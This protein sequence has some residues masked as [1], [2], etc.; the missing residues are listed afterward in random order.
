MPEQQKALIAAFASVFAASF[1][2]VFIRI[3]I[4]SGVNPVLLAFWRL[5]LTCLFMLPYTLSKSRYRRELRSLSKK[6]LILIT[7]AGLLLALHFSSWFISLKYTSTVSSTLLVCSEPAF[8]LI[9]A[10]IIYREKTNI[11]SIPGLL[12]AAV[13]VFL[14]ALPEAGNSAVTDTSLTGNFLALFGAICISGYILVGRGIMASVSTMLY[15]TFV[16]SVCCLCLGIMVAAMGVSFTAI[17]RTGFLMAICLAFFCQFLGNTTSNWSLKYI[18]AA[19]VSS[20]YLL[21]PV[22]TA[23]LVFLIWREVPGIAVI[24]GGL[25]LLSGILY[26]IRIEAAIEEKLQQKNNL[27]VLP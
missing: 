3:G 27:D 12:I 13:G 14:I 2:A 24:I 25:L 23:I 9:G 7:V 10:Y 22:G 6:E 4:S 26:F 15:C 17:N 8:V 1:S 18:K 16:Y 5:F 20:L 19:T 21:E 11:K